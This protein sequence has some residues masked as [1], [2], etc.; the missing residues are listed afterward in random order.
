MSVPALKFKDDDGRDFPEWEEMQ[1]GDIVEVMQSGVSRMLSDTDI[2]LLQENYGYI[3]LPTDLAVRVKM[4]Y[5][6]PQC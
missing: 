4:T 3:F 2:K 1:L 6:A 5:I